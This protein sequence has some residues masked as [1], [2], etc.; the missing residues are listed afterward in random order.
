MA[1]REDH[2]TLEVLEEISIDQRVTQRT[3]SQRLGMSLGMANLYMKRLA[4]KGYIKITTVPGKRLL[5]YMLTPQGLSEKTRLTYEFAEYSL[6][7]LRGA[8]GHMRAELSGLAERGMRRVVFCGD[9]ELAELAYLSLEE[10]GLDLV[11]VVTHAKTR[12]HFLGRDVQ[13]FSALADLDWDAVIVFSEE[14]RDRVVERVPD[15]ARV[16]LLTPGPV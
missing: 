11:G 12:G 8:R 9:G 6:R 14:D 10:C 3:L 7:F 16:I 2:R 4:K 5:R 1:D 15:D 13:P